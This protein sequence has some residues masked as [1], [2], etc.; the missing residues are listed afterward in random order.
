MSMIRLRLVL[1][2]NSC[3]GVFLKGAIK[4]C[5]RILYD[6]ILQVVFN[7]PPSS[8]ILPL[9]CER[10]SIK[11]PIKMGQCA[12]VPDNGVESRSVEKNLP[13]PL[14]SIPNR[15]PM[16]PEEWSTWGLDDLSLWAR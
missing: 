1:Q 12:S 15:L 10:S 14:P 16:V 11:L 8:S 2:V 3:A 13:A 5:A 7:K 6:A 9:F 4:P